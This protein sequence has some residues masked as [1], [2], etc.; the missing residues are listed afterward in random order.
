[1]LAEGEELWS[2]P[3]RFVFRGLQTTQAAVD[4]DWRIFDVVVAVLRKTLRANCS[5]RSGPPPGTSG[6]IFHAARADLSTTLTGNVTRQIDRSVAVL[7]AV[8]ID[9]NLFG[10][11]L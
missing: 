8:E 5:L 1:M 2:N 3:L 9:Q 6:K 4:V 11:L 10:A 7:R